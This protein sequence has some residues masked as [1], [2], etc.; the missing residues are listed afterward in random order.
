MEKPNIELNKIYNY[1]DD[2]KF[3]ESRRESVIINEIV[4][5]EDI[6]EETLLCWKEQ[7]V[8]ADWVYNSITDYFLK[9]E[10]IFEGYPNEPVVFVRTLENDFFSLG[11]WGGFLDVDEKF[12][13]KMLKQME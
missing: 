2:G 9:G 11:W 3:R 13:E 1:F 7:V 6:D 8:E 10:I 4:P 5:F 12:Y